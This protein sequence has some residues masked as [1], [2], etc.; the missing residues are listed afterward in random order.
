MKREK[1]ICKLRKWDDT[2]YVE[3]YRLARSGCT[4]AKICKVL[5]ISIPTWDRWRRQRPA[6]RKA[7]AL[8]RDNKANNFQAS[9]REYV[10]NRLSPDLQEV[11]DEINACEQEDAGI[12]RIEAL[13]E[14]KGERA[15]QHL[16]LYALV[17]SNFN[18]SEACRRINIST[19]TLRRWTQTDAGGFAAIMDEMHTHKGNFFEEG[20]VK[21]VRDGNTKAIIFANQTYN[22]D[23]GYSSK[24]EVEHKGQINHL[25]AIVSIDELDLPFEVKSTVLAAFRKHKQQGALEAEVV[26]SNSNGH[27][28]LSWDDE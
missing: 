1:R 13:L 12:A 17:D 15:R 8:A 19:G 20:L 24:L 18:P 16:F 27:G 25:H 10:Y 5:G 14:D 6:L 23:R 26:D 3:V 9:F 4:D 21:A 28:E 11:W 22:K 7:I 2:V